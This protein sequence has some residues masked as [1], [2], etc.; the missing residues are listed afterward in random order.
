MARNL[1][2]HG[3]DAAYRRHLRAGEPA[4]EECLAGERERKKAKR[5]AARVKLV[6]VPKVAQTIDALEEALDNLAIVKAAL[7]SGQAP[8]HTIAGL[9]K[10]RDELVDR[11]K[12]LQGSVSAKASV[13]DEL[14]SRRQRRTEATN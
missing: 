2:P 9:T 3:T 13:I 8:L 12:E 10:R 5:E 6:E 14:T 7:H 1:K 4:C 11:V